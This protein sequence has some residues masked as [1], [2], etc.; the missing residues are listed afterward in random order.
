MISTL[1]E[2]KMI[3]GINHIT[4]SVINLQSSI[5]F[6]TKVLGCK[7]KLTWDKGAYLLAGSLW[8]CLFEEKKENNKVIDYNHIAFDVSQDKFGL[9]K[10][11][12]EESGVNLWQN[13][14]SEGESIYFEDL[15][16]HRLEIH[17]G[18]LNSRIDSLKRG[19]PKKH[20]FY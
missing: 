3:N 5:L 4:L 16:G 6:Y 1:G 19:N 13:N 11:R 18:D 12:I 17:V 2:E 7:L 15:D 9:I 10:R 20:N 14:S 8:V